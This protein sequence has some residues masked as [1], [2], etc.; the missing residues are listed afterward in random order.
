MSDTK[1]YAIVVNLAGF[2][3]RVEFRS[4]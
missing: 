2:K 1:S 4:T 3:I